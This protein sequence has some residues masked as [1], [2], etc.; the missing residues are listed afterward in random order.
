MSINVPNCLR[1]LAHWVCWKYIER[2]GKSTKCPVNAVHGWNASSTDPN[3]W[4]TFDEAFASYQKS[5]TLAGVG[6]VFSAD[7]P[8]CGIDLDDCI[9]A[10]GNLLWGRDIIEM[11]DTYTE[12]SPSG[13]GVKLVFRGRKPPNARCKADWFGQGEVEIY[14]SGRFFCITGQRFPGTPAEV[15]D[16]QDQL[17]ALCSQLWPKFERQTDDRV[18]RCLEAMQRMRIIDHN[19]GSHRLHAACCRAVEHDLSDADA[20]ASV[21]AYAARFSFPTGLVGFGNPSPDTRR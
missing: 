3:S 9:D 16:R 14:D 17:D 18:E 5:D 12:V 15:N 7:D 4:C 10:E 6:F 8:F 1:N 20:V 2:S 13:R 11:F 19:D 21:R